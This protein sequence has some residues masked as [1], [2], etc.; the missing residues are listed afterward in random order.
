MRRR[1]PTPSRRDHTLA[2]ST[3]RRLWLRGAVVSAA[4]TLLLTPVHAFV[5]ATGG[6]LGVA[7]V[8]AT[9]YTAALPAEPVAAREI[10]ELRWLHPG[11]SASVAPLL[12]DHVFPALSR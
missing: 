8:T 10:A 5:V 3:R 1:W 6:G 9:V 12:R 2:D 7:A 11:G 4:A